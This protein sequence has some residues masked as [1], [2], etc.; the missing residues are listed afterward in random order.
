MQELEFIS[1]HR[2]ISGI[3]D[4]N[5]IGCGLLAR[6]LSRVIIPKPKNEIII[7]TLHDF[8]L[9]INPVID[10]G[11]EQSL[12]YTGT[13]EKGILHLMEFLLKKGDVFIDVGANIGVMSIHAALLVGEKGLVYAFEANPDTMK[14]LKYNIGINNLHNITTS[15]YALGDK[16][17][18]GRIYTSLDH[19]RGRASLFE[20]TGKSDYYEVDII[21]LSDFFNTKPKIKLIKVDIEGFE[22]QALKGFGDIL[23]GDEAPILIVECTE[24]EH[25]EQA[26]RKEIW[27]FIKKANNYSIY[28]LSAGKERTSHL[29]KIN[30]VDELPN[31]DNIICLLEGHLKEIDQKIFKSK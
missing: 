8:R 10:S 23:T 21:P 13:Y 30:S 31:H 20:P 28:K 12:Y 4:L 17:D 26:S 5:I 27:D 24:R 2:F 6:Y 9:K 11:I 3:R 15:G 1:K 19:N 16:K 25:K 29:V 18:K 7:K 14:I 22:I